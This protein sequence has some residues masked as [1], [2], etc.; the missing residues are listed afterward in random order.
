MTQPAAFFDA[1]VRDILS[2]IAPEADTGALRSN[3]DMRDGL[4]IDSVDFLNF[5]ASIYER[6][7]VDIPERD[8]PML[9]T[10]DGC[11]NYLSKAT[12]TP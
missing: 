5:V 8:Y 4:N 2:K 9:S 7:G 6:T 10:V 1:M 11:V 12:T 3:A